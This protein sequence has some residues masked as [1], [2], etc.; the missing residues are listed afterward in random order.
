MGNQEHLS[1]EGS[2]KGGL[3]S[4]QLPQGRPGQVGC[5]SGGHIPNKCLKDVYLGRA[6]RIRHKEVGGLEQGPTAHRHSLHPSLSL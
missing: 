1:V 4:Q 2:L 6:E 3:C 5:S